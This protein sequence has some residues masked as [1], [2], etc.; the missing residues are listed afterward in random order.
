MAYSTGISSSIS[1]LVTAVI[2]FATSNGWTSGSSWTSGSYSLVTISKNSVHF[3]FQYK[4]DE[5]FINTAKGV[6]G[7]GLAT[8]Q[9]NAVSLNCEVR[10][11]TGPHVGYHLFTDGVALH[12]AVEVATNSFTHFSFGEVTKTGTFAGGQFV[13]VQYA[14]PSA[15]TAGQLDILAGQ[16]SWPFAS[17]VVGT[18]QGNGV[19]FLSHMRMD[20]LGTNRVHVF[21]GTITPDAANTCWSL[22]WA[23][24]CGRRLIEKS[25]NVFNGRSV[26]IPH[27]IICS[28]SGVTSPYYQVGSIPNAGVLNIENI[29]PKDL[30]NTDWMVFPIGVKGTT[31]TTNINSRNFGVAYKK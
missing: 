2:S 22:T 6:T 18:V 14:P 1:D 30:V 23:S 25:P 31:A 27:T 9:T 29:A 16:V 5:L 17:N 7:S 4:S 28:T 13:T 24:T 12:V 8:A 20:V 15:T 10:P 19:T 21:S 3:V 26:I 11:I